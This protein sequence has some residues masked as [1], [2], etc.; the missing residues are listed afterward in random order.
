[1]LTV[2]SLMT[3]DPYTAYPDATLRETLMIMK[4]KGVRQIPV[5]DAHKHLLGIVTDRDIRLA[6]NSPFVGEHWL[7][8]SVLD[9]TTIRSCMSTGPI[10]VSP[11]T[12][13]YEAAEILSAHKYGALPV[14]DENKKVVGIITTT[15]FLDFSI[16]TLKKEASLPV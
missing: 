14:V 3:T 6:I 5:V 13:A 7:D 16:L 4:T 9:N 15:D 1:M 12:P 11:N 10:T 2:R 8:N